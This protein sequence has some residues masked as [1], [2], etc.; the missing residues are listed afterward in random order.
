MIQTAKS[1]IL[2]A[3]KAGY[4]HFD[5]AFIY[6]SEKP[7]GEAIA[8]ALRLGLIKSREELFIPTKLWCSFAE[9]DQVVPAC[10]LSLE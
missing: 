2:E 1:A 4:R 5:T 9:R 8:E 6:G 7:L 10:K 3:M